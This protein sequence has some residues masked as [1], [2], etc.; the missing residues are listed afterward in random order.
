MWRNT[1]WLHNSD[2]RCSQCD[3]VRA[4]SVP[5]ELSCRG[6]HQLMTLRSLRLWILGGSTSNCIRTVIAPT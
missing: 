5:G 1:L 3:E 6:T 2:Q 4:A